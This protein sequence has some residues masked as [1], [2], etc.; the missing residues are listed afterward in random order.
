MERPSIQGFYGISLKLTRISN[1]VA[2]EKE[3]PFIDLNKQSP[4]DPLE[5]FEDEEAQ[6]RIGILFVFYLQ[7]VKPQI[8]QPQKH[9]AHRKC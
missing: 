2:P 6:L 9:S 5:I 8:Q 7:C 1:Q 3:I 4:N